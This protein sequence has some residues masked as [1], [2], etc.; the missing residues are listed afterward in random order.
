MRTA[1]DIIDTSLP[2]GVAERA[3]RARWLRLLLPAT[4]GLLLVAAVVGITLYSAQATRNDALQLTNDLIGALETA[5][6]R[7]V[8][9]YLAAPRAVVRFV[10]DMADQGIGDDPAADAALER[11]MRTVVRR[12]RSLAAVFVGDED[13]DFLMVQ[14][15]PNGG[16]L[17]KRIIERPEQRTVRVVE[18]DAAGRVLDDRRVAEDPFDPRTR[19]WF[20]DARDAPGVRWTDVYRFFTSGELGVTAS[21]RAEVDTDA[22]GTVAGVDVELTTMNAFLDRVELGA[23]G[24]LAIIQGNGRLIAFPAEKDWALGE[25]EGQLSHLDDLNDPALDNVYQR[26]RVGGSVRTVAPIS[27]DRYI[28]SAS[29]L[30]AVVGRD[31]WL[32]LVVPESEFVGFVETNARQTLVL[33]LLVVAL[34]VGAAVLFTVQAIR[35]DTRL[36]RARRVE[37][38]AREQGRV[39]A[40][41]G[42]IRGLG[43]PRDTTALENLTTLLGDALGARRTGV[44]RLDPAGRRLASLEVYDREAHGHTTAASLSAGHLEPHWTTLVEGRPFVLDAAE[45]PD[46]SLVRFYLEPSGTRRLRSVPIAAQGGVLGAL[47][48]EDAAVATTRIA[49]VDGVLALA[50]GLVA[51]RLRA[52]PAGADRADLGDFEPSRVPASGGI[53]EVPPAAL[54]E[55]SIAARRDQGFLGAVAARPEGVQQLAAAVFPRVA[56]LSLRFGDD[57]VLASADRDGGVVAERLVER[58][59]A[60][61]ERHG[62][63]YVKL[64][65]DEVMAAEG[66]D[67][68]PDRAIRGIAELA[69]ELQQLC[70]EAFADTGRPPTYRLGIDVATA[71]GAAVGF[72]E[73]AF[74]LW[75]GAVRLAEALAATAPVGTI[76]VS[77]SAYRALAADYLLRRRGAFFIAN[78]GVTETYVLVSPL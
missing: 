42:E 53:D 16:L 56:V 57:L 38:L 25:G 45:A 19:P 1:E 41:I 4:M 74:D 66:F 39:L 58:I 21:V 71:M 76:Q 22:P 10:A 50:A 2:P 62:I 11:V 59:S 52:E 18:R 32:L 48:V 61:A 5:V 34:A 68:E 14:R 67:G 20:R 78:V 37:E 7:E 46:A 29:S 6:Q 33:A 12:A 77:E 60:A 3:W 44:W 73:R 28:L 40:A 24:R 64:L 17:T 27:G 35:A 15:Q 9:A 63:R 69:L 31:W 75:G 51:S 49:A 65:G 70:R 54:R 43:D 47:W 8:Q 30:D 26:F 23:G 13:G 72:D 36:A 55:A